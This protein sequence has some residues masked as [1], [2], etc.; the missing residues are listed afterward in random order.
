[1]TRWAGIVEHGELH[2]VP[3]LTDPQASVD[4]DSWNGGREASRVWAT[5][6]DPGRD[7]HGNPTKA[8]HGG[9]DTEG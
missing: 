4:P 5:A 2:A 9:R 8:S 7:K 1:M 3:G 6:C